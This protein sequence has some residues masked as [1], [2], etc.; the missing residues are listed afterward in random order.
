ME[1]IAE[2]AGSGVAAGGA[3][4]ADL[5]PFDLR[6]FPGTDRPSGRAVPERAERPLA[7]R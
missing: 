7:R 2:I 5:G 1:I 4:T 6:A 3:S